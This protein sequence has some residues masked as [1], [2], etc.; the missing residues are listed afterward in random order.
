MAEDDRRA[1]DW[2][3]RDQRRRA[4]EEGPLQ[5]P[6]SAPAKWYDQTF[7]I[8]FFL[9]VLWPVGLVMMWRGACTWHVAVKVIVTIAILGLVVVS[10]QMSQAVLA[11]QGTLG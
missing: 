4:R 11:A 3:H 6:S 7:W 8:V 9:I 10:Y 2:L 1:G 5:Q